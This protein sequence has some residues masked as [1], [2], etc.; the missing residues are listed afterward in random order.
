M[1]YES[2]EV[3]HRPAHTLQPKTATFIHHFADN[4]DI[5]AYN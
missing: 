3:L 4:A 2:P 5:K 1:M